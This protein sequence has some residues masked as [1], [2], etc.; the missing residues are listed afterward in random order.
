MR[1]DSECGVGFADWTGFEPGDHI[2]CYEELYE[3]RQL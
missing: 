1:K 2:Q 3:K